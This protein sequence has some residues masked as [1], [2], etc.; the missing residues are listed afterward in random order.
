MTAV[1]TDSLETTSEIIEINNLSEFKWNKVFSLIQSKIQG[2]QY[3]I[4][5]NIIKT[6]RD[7]L[8]FNAVSINDLEGVIKEPF[9]V[10]EDLKPICKEFEEEISCLIIPTGVGA[11]FGGYAGDANPIAK[12]LAAQSDYL[13]THPNVVNGAVLSDPPSNLIYLEGFLLDQFLLGNIGIN[14]EKGNK[15]GVIFDK[16]ISDERLEY[17]I[18]VL[19][20][21]KTFYGCDISCWTV[22]EKPLNVIP[23]INSFGFSEGKIEN[24]D[25]LLQ[26][27]NK[28]KEKG[29]TAIGIC[30]AI[31]DLELNSKYLSGSGI[32]PIGGIESLIS[33]VVSAHTG[34]VSAHAPVLTNT[35]KTD[36]ENIAPVSA[37]EY[38]AQTFLP[39]V[40]SG[41]RFA[42]KTVNQNPTVN[43]QQLSSIVVPYNAFGSP[44]VLYMNERFNNIILIKENRTSLNVTPE[45]LNM[46]FK[47]VNK[48]TDLTNHERIKQA[49]VNFKI[50]DR[51][52]KKIPQL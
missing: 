47:V 44:G 46:E 34:L 48:Y 17:E 7:K 8:W 11:S 41:L 13:I 52:V 5:L 29:V 50:F 18:N 26:S 21:L 9:R 24:L 28:L 43:N 33:R 3:L 40:I 30:C 31:P 20:A 25:S 38:I 4:K 32:D 15:I 37:A 23:S 2:N 19:N 14:P 51:P 39:S 49:K 16:A 22:T 42:P 36:Y 10:K 1:K 27:S 6:T 12:L 35:E 45:H